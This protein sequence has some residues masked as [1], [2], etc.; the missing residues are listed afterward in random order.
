[1][2]GV[3]LGLESD[4]ELD[5]L[6]QEITVESVEKLIAEVLHRVHIQTLVHGNLSKE[7][8]T[9]LRIMIQAEKDS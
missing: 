4:S 9:P 7:V 6:L 8:S 1:M 3:W 5:P 2:W